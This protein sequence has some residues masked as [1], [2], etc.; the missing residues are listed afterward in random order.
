[1]SG[2]ER[3]KTSTDE[4]MTPKKA[5]VSVLTEYGM[6]KLWTANY[7]PAIPFTPQNFDIGNLLPAILYMFRWGHRRGKGQFLEKYGEIQNEK[8]TY[9][10]V[11]GISKILSQKDEF[12]GFD[13]ATAKAILGDMLLSSCLE[14]KS[15]QTGR[16]EQ[17]QRAYPAH[18]L[19]SWIDLPLKV[20][21]LRFVPEMLVALLLNQ[22]EGE[23]I[24]RSTRRTHFGI[25]CGFDE[26]LLLSL[27]GNGMAISGSSKALNLTSDHFIEDDISVGIDQLLTIR[28][29][30]GC[31][32]RPAKAKSGEG[33]Q[34]LNQWPIAT[35]AMNAL[36]EDFSVFVQAYGGS[37]PRQTFLQML[38]S[39]L[40]LGLT[41]I[42]FSTIS[43]LSVWEQ[44]GTLPTQEDQRPWPFFVDCSNGNDKGLRLLAEESM[45]HFIR[46][47]GRLPIIL[48]AMRIIDF[49]VKHDDD[50]SE[51][52]PVSCPDGTELINLLGS[53]YK[54]THPLAGQV[55][56]SLKKQ[57]SKI[58]T[59][60]KESDL[61]QD[62]QDLLRNGNNSPIDRL[63]ES[64]C[65]LMGDNLHTKYHP[66]VT[67]SV[68][69]TDLPNGLAQ[70]RRTSQKSKSGTIA[71]FDVRSIVLTNPML[72]FIVHRHLRKAAKGKG[73]KPLTFIDLLQIL[74]NR[75]G[76]HVAE[77]P[78]GMSIPVEMLL[79]NK[80]ILERRLRDLGVLVGVNDAES[81]KRLRQ[82]FRTVGDEE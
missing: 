78:P 15:H 43:M 37:I 63:S 46:Q 2:K 8:K 49:E 16:A 57:C 28:V 38:E 76:L 71:R 70:K 66:M 35:N 17:V 52:L 20:A 32:E 13:T 9:A 50:I 1:M 41:N 27:F 80:R 30:Q 18:Y 77:S 29:A 51:S 11:D 59:I 42:Y 3:E 33:E 25:G 54:E 26:N 53:F 10:T 21:T 45:S 81:M 36:R 6:K 14:N 7:Q 34:I 69:M 58:A 24:Q 72:D 31:G 65:I 48:M 5:F 75:Y 44:T 23:T 79:H 67:T 55:I 60:L 12:S 19:A 56:S 39:S 22:K 61:D 68:L 47:L 62:L 82:R 40:S 74:K 4:G 73:S 64:L